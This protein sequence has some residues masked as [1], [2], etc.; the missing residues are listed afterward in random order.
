MEKLNRIGFQL[1]ETKDSEMDEIDW[2]GNKNL[3]SSRQYWIFQ[4]CLILLVWLID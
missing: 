3:D 4:E 2:A 1:P